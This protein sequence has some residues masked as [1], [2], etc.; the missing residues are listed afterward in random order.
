[1]STT[2]PSGA[3]A[4]GGSRYASLRTFTRDGRAI[5]SPIWFL[6]DGDRLWFRSA[7]DTPKIRRIGNDPRVELRPC[8][9]KGVVTGDVVV[10]GTARVLPRSEAVEPERRMARRYGWQWNLVPLISVPG[11]STSSMKLSLRDYW[12]LWRGATELWPEACV[13]EC[14]LRSPGSTE[15]AQ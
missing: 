1:M 9:W 2:Q 14:T 4:L 8:T 15:A 3:T 11:A 12:R 7:E 6:V 5:D 13:V 10:T